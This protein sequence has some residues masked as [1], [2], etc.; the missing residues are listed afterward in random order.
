MNGDFNVMHPNGADVHFNAFV[1]R[2]GGLP[3][4]S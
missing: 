4:K 3:F 2:E 1:S